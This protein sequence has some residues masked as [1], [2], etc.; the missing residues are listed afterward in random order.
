LGSSCDRVETPRTIT[1]ASCGTWPSRAVA[2]ALARP[3]APR[4]TD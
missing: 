1:G 3:E 4:S 2:L